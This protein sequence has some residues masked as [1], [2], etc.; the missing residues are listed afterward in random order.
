[1]QWSYLW[2]KVGALCA[3]DY[4]WVQQEQVV[5]GKIIPVL[6]H[7]ME[8]SPP[9]DA[10]YYKGCGERAGI[11]REIIAVRVKDKMK[12]KNYPCFTLKIRGGC[13]TYIKPDGSVGTA[14]K[15]PL[16]QTE[17]SATLGCNQDQYLFVP[18]KEYGK[19]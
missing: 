9:L 15:G 8:G 19:T 16:V 1:M 10:S 18:V 2:D 3:T 7:C 12:D 13:D 6:F 5:Q 4:K 17:I 14:G 11:E